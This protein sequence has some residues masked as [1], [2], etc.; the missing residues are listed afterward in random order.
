MADQWMIR[1]PVYSN[2]NCSYACGCQFQ[3]PTTHGFCETVIGGV[4]EEGHFNN[5]QLGGLKW[6]MLVAWPGEIAEG[7]GKQQVIIE[8]SATPE[9]REALRKILHGDCTAP[10]S[11][12]LN[13]V[14]SLMAEVKETLYAPVD[15]EV[16]VEARKG[17]INVPGLVESTGSPIP[18]P[19][20]GGPHGISISIDQ[21]IEYQTANIGRG[22]SKA[23]A[24]LE[25]ELDNSYGQ[26]CVYHLNQDGLI[27]N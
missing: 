15:V 25:I 9:Q 7:N 8:E 3:A 4:L 1:G 11:T 18:N 20:S 17:K 22:N 2:C 24:G 19:F 10:G 23:T 14:N 5:V 16:D 12:F 13:I 21:G 6:V 26:F 27:R